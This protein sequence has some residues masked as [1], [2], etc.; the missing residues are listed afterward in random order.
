MRKVSRCPS[1]RFLRAEVVV[2]VESLVHATVLFA[3]Y[4][5]A[6]GRLFDGDH[7]SVAEMARKLG[8]ALGRP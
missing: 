1:A 4:P 8:L 5:M 3:V 2:M 6:E 7:P